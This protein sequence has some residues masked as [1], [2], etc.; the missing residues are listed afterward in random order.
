M[1]NVKK[2]ISSWLKGMKGRLF[3]I[4]R[5]PPKEKEKNL[6]STA[7]EKGFLSLNPKNETTDSQIADAEIWRCMETI[8]FKFG[9][10][11]YTIKEAGLIFVYKTGIENGRMY[12]IALSEKCG[13]VIFYIPDDILELISER[14]AGLM[15]S[16]EKYIADLIELKDAEKA[17]LQSV[18]ASG[19]TFEEATAA[20][21]AIKDAGE[22]AGHSAKAATE[23]L[24]R[25]GNALKDCSKCQERKSN[26][27]LKMHGFPMRRKRK[28]IQK[29]YLL[30]NCN[31]RK[32]RRKKKNARKAK[33]RSRQNR[34]RRIINLWIFRMAWI[35]NCRL[36]RG[37]E[38][39]NSLKYNASGY[40]DKVAER[41]IRAADHTPHE[42]SELIDVIKKI[43]AAYGYDIEGRIAF[44]DKKTK[45]IYK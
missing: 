24:V 41:A 18:A 4:L 28:Y 26:N 9:K 44:Q 36:G 11:I 17:L 7:K 23:A 45:I 3:A 21:Y 43:S 8:E 15:C 19:V 6:Q 13:T 37:C 38:M 32:Q 14:A 1:T 20:V 22:R 10:E 5:K 27:W 39:E 2:N 34:R 25:L 30:R 29:L 12:V 42:I 16:P 40:R 35:K 33:T 31:S